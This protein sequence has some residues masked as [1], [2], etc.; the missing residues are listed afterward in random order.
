MR[1]GI[2]RNGV[3]LLMVLPLASCL[4]WID[5][6]DYV[7][8]EPV[9]SPLVVVEPASG[10]LCGEA[11]LAEVV[12]LYCAQER[13]LC[14]QW[15][16]CSTVFTPAEQCV[17]ERESLCVERAR[18]ALAAGACLLPQAFAA[19]SQ[20]GCH[21]SWLQALGACVLPTLQQVTAVAQLCQDEWTPGLIAKGDVCSYGVPGC[22]APDSP[23]LRSAC[24]Y[25][26]STGIDGGVCTW[27]PDLPRGAP[28]DADAGDYCNLTDGCL[29]SGVC[30]PRY[31]LGEGCAA[32]NDCANGLCA[33]G[34]CTD[35]E[36]FSCA[37]RSCPISWTCQ[38][39]RC[40]RITR[41]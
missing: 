22:A 19:N 33:S 36:G 30:G 5:V 29:S 7:R 24:Y 32:D 14:Q 40:T 23:D 27:V 17:A 13:E 16:E 10:P 35:P 39:S 1:K 11:S 34:V 8:P 20:N 41:S 18:Y 12:A 21:E 15:A 38:D 2:R 28:C 31:Q 25:E 26:T 3:W 9:P 6:E 4:D 37:E